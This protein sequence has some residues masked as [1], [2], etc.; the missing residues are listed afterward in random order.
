MPCVLDVGLTAYHLVAAALSPAACCLGGYCLACELVLAFLAASLLQ[1]QSVSVDWNAA[2]RI[3]AFQLPAAQAPFAA[4]L[5][6]SQ[7]RE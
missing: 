3:S 6:P 5:P 2:A 4:S 1:L 7:L